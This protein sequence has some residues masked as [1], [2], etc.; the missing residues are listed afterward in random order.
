LPSTSGK[1]RRRERAFLPEVVLDQSISK[2]FDEVA[3]MRNF[4][5]R[6]LAT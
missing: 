1:K 2:S 5:G 6:R 3:K 4:F